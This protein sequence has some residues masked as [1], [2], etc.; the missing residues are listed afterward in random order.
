MK[1]LG[2]GVLVEISIIQESRLKSYP[3]TR[4]I[5]LEVQRGNAASILGVLGRSVL[6]VVKE[7]AGIPVTNTS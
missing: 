4:I 2:H 7:S 5:A 6:L 1:E 3:V